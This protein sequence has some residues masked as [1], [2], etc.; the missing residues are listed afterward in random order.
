MINLK[1]MALV[2]VGLAVTAAASQAAITLNFSAVPGSEIQFNGTAHTFQ[3][4]NATGGLFGG[5]QW[6]IT[7]TDPAASGD[8]IGTSGSF[9]F[10]LPGNTWH[11]GAINPGDAGAEVAIVDPTPAG[12]LYID[13]GTGGSLT[14]KLVWSTVQTRAGS[15]GLNAGL[16]LNITDMVYT[17]GSTPVADLVALASYVNAKADLSFTFSSPAMSLTE[18]SKGSGPYTTTAYSGSI[19]A[20]PEPSTC[21]AG[22]SALVMMALFG[23]KHNGKHTTAISE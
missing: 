20:V 5:L 6:Q 3:I 16:Q 9:S 11:Y 4:N 2:A 8:S 12:Q 18:L 17:P 13:A 1:T 14:G 10:I 22:F 19:S 21:L 15:G 23:L 7:S